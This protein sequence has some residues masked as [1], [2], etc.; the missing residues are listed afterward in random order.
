VASAGYLQASISVTLKSSE[1]AVK[2]IVL[3]KAVGLGNVNGVVLDQENNPVAGATI[4]WTGASS[5]QKSTAAD[6]SYSISS[7]PLGTY[8][9]IASKVGFSA[10]QKE[11]II[12]DQINEV[13]YQLSSTL[14]QGYLGKSY[15]D[16][17]NNRKLDGNDK[18]VYGAKMYA[19]GAFK[20]YS[21]YPSGDYKIPLTIGN[22]SILA[23]YQDYSSVLEAHNIES[24]KSFTVNLLLIQQIGE[25]SAPNLP[26]DV[27]SITANHV[28]GRQEVLLQW[29]KPCPEVLNYFIT[30]YKGS[31][32]LD[33]FTVSPIDVI[34]RDADVDCGGVYKYEI[35]AV[36]DKGQTSKKAAT[37]LITLGDKECENRYDETTGWD[38]F[39][40]SESSQRKKILSCDSHNKL[41]VSSDCSEQDGEGQVWFCAQV[42]EHNA[43]CKDAGMCGTV[44]QGADPFGLY[45]A[46]NTCYGSD[47]P[48]TGGTSNYCYYDYSN[49]ITD[50]CQRCD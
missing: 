19:D 49:T 33:E 44:S 5:G 26:K 7:L 46:R 1:K 32:K 2:E 23:T 30:K 17:N 39:C 11:V 37:A 6:G 24:G 22:H 20:G 48:G 38:L 34:Y 4:S 16:S 40:S 15:I 10:Q 43:V 13:N 47:E 8:T 21:Q 18:A 36:Y 50:V 42:G 25:C 9:I 41:I 3:T 35:L 27:A 14:F 29:T 31:E 12:S 45:H 28:K